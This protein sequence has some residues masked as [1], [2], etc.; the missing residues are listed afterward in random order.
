MYIKKMAVNAAKERVMLQCS[1]V[2]RQFHFPHDMC[3]P[4]IS[5]LSGLVSNYDMNQLA[6]L[7]V[8]IHQMKVCLNSISH[9]LHSTIISPHGN[10]FEKM[11][12]TAG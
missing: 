5:D 1:Q 3:P 12:A 6:L 10:P 9:F 8:N 7:S 2:S 4:D 11:E